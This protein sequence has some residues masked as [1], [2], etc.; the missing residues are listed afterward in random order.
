MADTEGTG[1]VS[2]VRQLHLDGLFVSQGTSTQQGG[3]LLPVSSHNHTGVMLHY[4]KDFGI[5]TYMYMYIIIISLKAQAT[6][7]IHVL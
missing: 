2:C 6:P 7:Q 4:E 5:S 1:K 3:K